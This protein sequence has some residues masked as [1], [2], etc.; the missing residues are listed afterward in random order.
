MSTAPA[1]YAAWAAWVDGG[2]VGP[3]PKSAPRLIPVWAWRLRRAQRPAVPAYPAPAAV[4]REDVVFTVN[5]SSFGDAHRAAARAEGFTVLAVLLD[6]DPSSGPNRAELSKISDR[7]RTQ[8]WKIVGWAPTYTAE[9]ATAAGDIV[10]FFRLDGWIANLEAWAEGPNKALTADWL[11]QWRVASG[12][13]VPLAVSMLSSDTGLSLRDFDHAACL[14]AGAMLMPQVYSNVAGDETYTVAA[15]VAQLKL[16]KVPASHMSLTF[17]VYGDRLPGA[18]RVAFQDY[19]T[20]A[21]PRGVYVGERLDPD[22]WK[23]LRR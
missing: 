17:G 3:R 15:A 4:W 7:L 11:Y 20:W 16:A 6:G 10:D 12:G 22:Q 5:L 19:R 9:Q 1:W 21:G 14:K 23:E 2:R 8:G 18:S 13:G